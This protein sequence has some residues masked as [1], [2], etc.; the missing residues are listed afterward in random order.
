MT[1]KTDKII[2]TTSQ[3]SI[4]EDEPND[5]MSKLGKIMSDP[6][7]KEFFKNYFQDWTDIKTAIMF[8]KTYAFIDEEYHKN[9]GHH[10]DPEELVD[11]LRKMI[12]NGDCRR[13]IVQNMDGFM[14]DK[15][16]FLEHYH[17]VNPQL[18]LKN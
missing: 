15:T 18:L 5:F 12:K 8:M 3:D 14:N 6:Q 17:N 9:A 2:I 13:L 1:Y 7:F 10:M 16:K 4:S 11:I